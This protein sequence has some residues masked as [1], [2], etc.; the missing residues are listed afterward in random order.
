MYEMFVSSNCDEQSL[1]E[2]H[3]CEDPAIALNWAVGIYN[4]DI[5]CKEQAGFISP[6]VK[7]ISEGHRDSLVVCK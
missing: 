1:C 6:G 2:T 7:I 3:L 4:N 5:A